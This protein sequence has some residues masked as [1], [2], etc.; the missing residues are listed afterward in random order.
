MPQV[1][2]VFRSVRYMRTGSKTHRTGTAHKGCKLPFR[3]YV[4][5]LFQRLGLGHIFLQASVQTVYR[6]G[7]EALL[8]HL[9]GRE[10]RCERG[11]DAGIIEPDNGNV[12]RDAVSEPQKRFARLALYGAN[13]LI[14]RLTAVEITHGKVVAE[15]VGFFGDTLRK[16]LEKQGIP[17]HL[18]VTLIQNELQK[19]ACLVLQY[20]HRTF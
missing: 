6:Q 10:R 19:S 4:L 15:R 18:A 16:P 5:L 13:L 3:F 9:H 12:L 17:Y 14:S 11:A 20:P 7:S 8:L 2:S 1:F